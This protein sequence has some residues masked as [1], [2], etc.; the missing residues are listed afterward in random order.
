M[1]GELLTS[2]DGLSNLLLWMGTG[3]GFKTRSFL[4]TFT[5]DK[6]FVSSKLE[7]TIE[8]FQDVVA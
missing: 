8:K 7:D 1:P 4:E 2:K 6:Q 5:H 3:Q